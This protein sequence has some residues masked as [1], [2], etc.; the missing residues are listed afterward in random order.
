MQMSRPV[1]SVVPCFALTRAQC[2]LSSLSCCSM[3]LCWMNLSLISWYSPP[4]NDARS[5]F[6]SGTDIAQHLQLVH[7]LQGLNFN[8]SRDVIPDPT[9][10]AHCGIIFQTID[11]VKS[12]VVQG[13]CQY[14]DPRATAETLEVEP[15]WQQA[16]LDGQLHCVAKSHGQNATHCSV[17]N[18]WQ[19]LPASG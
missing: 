18:V 10:C 3:V 7:N 16:C 6:N 12:H 11:G 8:A 2:L 15:R 14:Y 1:F 19:G 4:G 5:I 9:A 17:P 13:R